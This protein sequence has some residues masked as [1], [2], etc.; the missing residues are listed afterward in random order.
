MAMSG[1]LAAQAPAFA[2]EDRGT[3]EQQMACTPDAFRLCGAMIP[4]AERITA[5][6]RQNTPFL[7]GPCRAVF[8]PVASLPQ[9]TQPRTRGNVPRPTNIRPRYHD[10]DDE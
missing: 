5:C 6:L 7:S 8:E 10:D 9:Q 4:D 2:Q 1:G 3:P